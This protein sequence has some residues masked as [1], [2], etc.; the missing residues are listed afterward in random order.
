MSTSNFRQLQP[1]S[2]PSIWHHKS[3]TSAPTLGHRRGQMGLLDVSGPVPVIGPRFTAM[4]LLLA[5]NWAVKDLA[6]A[7]QTAC[8]GHYS[9][10][11]DRERGQITWDFHLSEEYPRGQYNA[12]MAAADVMTEGAWWR[13][14]NMPSSERFDEPTVCDVDFPTVA[15]TRA[16]WDGKAQQLHLAMDGMNGSV[17]GRP[18]TMRVTGLGDLSRWTAR[19]SDGLQVEVTRKGLRPSVAHLSRPAESGCRTKVGEC[20]SLDAARRRHRRTADDVPERLGVGERHWVPLND[21]Y[22]AAR[23]T[24]WGY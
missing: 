20:D 17:N 3:L 21:A 14:S 19:G 4:A 8:D 22:G 24:V 7:L 15:L 6:D 5:R 23:S 18:T 1:P 10:T 9:P 11:R 13:L 16:E 2:R 12:M